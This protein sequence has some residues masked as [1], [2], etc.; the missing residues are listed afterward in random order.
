VWK[1][2]AVLAGELHLGVARRFKKMAQA[3]TLNA[4]RISG[5]SSA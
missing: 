3:A 4:V 5:R 2:S 1:R